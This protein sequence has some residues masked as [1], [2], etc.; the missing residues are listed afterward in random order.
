MSFDRPN[1]EVESTGI[2]KRSNGTRDCPEPP[3]PPIS[4]LHDDILWHIF[5]LNTPTDADII[6]SPISMPETS[7]PTLQFILLRSVRA[8]GT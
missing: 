1:N 3:S 8:G 5:A 4:M 6:E 7:L 2:S